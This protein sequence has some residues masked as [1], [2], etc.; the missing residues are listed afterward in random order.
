[1]Q[2]SCFL[3]PESMA[4]QKQPGHA[5]RAQASGDQYRLSRYVMSIGT[6]G[7]CACR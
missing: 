3:L 1:M 4:L 5:L 7:V 2:G 6:E